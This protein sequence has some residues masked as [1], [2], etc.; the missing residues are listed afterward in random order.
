MRHLN[1]SS[2]QSGKDPKQILAILN[3]HIFL[4]CSIATGYPMETL[5]FNSR[6]AA[7]E[8]QDLA[9]RELNSLPSDSLSR[10]SA[11][12]SSRSGD[13]TP[14][15]QPHRAEASKWRDWLNCSGN[16]KAAKFLHRIWYQLQVCASPQIVTII[17]AEVILTVTLMHAQQGM[18]EVNDC[19]QSLLNRHNVLCT[20]I[21][22]LP[23]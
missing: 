21:I 16:T 8:D 20:W 18:Q 13:L 1:A 4:T 17:L 7:L 3:L 22:E 6:Q 2:V 10:S 9:R 5:L 12:M 11:S 23:I 14:Q 15:L 19:L